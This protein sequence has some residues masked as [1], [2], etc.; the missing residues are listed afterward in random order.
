MFLEIKANFY[1]PIIM[2]ESFEPN[3]TLRLFLEFC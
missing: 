2:I 1:L 3:V